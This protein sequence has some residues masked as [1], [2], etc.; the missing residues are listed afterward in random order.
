MTREKQSETEWLHS[1]LE[2][3]ASNRALRCWNETTTEYKQLVDMY[4]LKPQEA[5]DM[6]KDKYALE[7]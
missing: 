3:I 5:I 2:L 1:Q 4:Q 7:K 6:L